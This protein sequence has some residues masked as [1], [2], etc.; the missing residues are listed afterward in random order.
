[1]RELMFQAMMQA[2]QA[3][4]RFRSEERGAS[5]MV[6]V[7]VLIVIII[8]VAAIFREKLVEI[9]NNVMTDLTNATK[10]KG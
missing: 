3:F 7:I 1:M 10:Q 4:R 2:K 5:D 6:A 8:A 9:V